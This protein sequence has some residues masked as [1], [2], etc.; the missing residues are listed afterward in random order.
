M[1]FP[2]PS[3]SQFTIYSKSGCPNCTKAKNLLKEK[4]LNF[5]IV[6][7]DDFLIEDKENFLIFIQDISGKEYRTFPMIFDNK[8]FIGGFTEMQKYLDTFLDFEMSF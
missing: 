3:S 8:K 6:D 2:L 5:N 4:N 1:E 7:C